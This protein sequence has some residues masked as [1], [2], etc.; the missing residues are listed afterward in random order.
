MFVFGLISMFIGGFFLLAVFTGSASLFNVI[1]GLTL[2]ILGCIN[3]FSKSENKYR[4]SISL[5]AIF[6][7]IFFLS[8]F[9]KNINEGSKNKDDYNYKKKEEKPKLRPTINFHDSNTSVYRMTPHDDGS[10]TIEWVKGSGQPGAMH[11]TFTVN[12]L[13][14]SKTSITSAKDMYTVFWS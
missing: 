6:A 7:G 2:F 9:K 8:R 5:M 14:G 3:V 4:G 13:E 12:Y 10:W 11:G 1:V